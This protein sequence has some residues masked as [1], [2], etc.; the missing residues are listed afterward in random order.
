MKRLEVCVGDGDSS[1]LNY[2]GVGHAPS[3]VA[4]RYGL[5][6]ADVEASP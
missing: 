4:S 2:L 3:I 5:V 6:V 1:Q